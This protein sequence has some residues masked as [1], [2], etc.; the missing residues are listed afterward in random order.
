MTRLT[1]RAEKSGGQFSWREFTTING[2]EN[3]LIFVLFW[4][5]NRN[6]RTPADFWSAATRHRF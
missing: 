2:I 6:G 1:K 4:I 3:A 5:P